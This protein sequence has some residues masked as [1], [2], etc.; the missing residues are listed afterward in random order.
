[1]LGSGRFGW[2]GA[3]LAEAKALSALPVLISGKG[4]GG[5]VGIWERCGQWSPRV[6]LMH[7]AVRLFCIYPRI[8]RRGLRRWRGIK[9][10]KHEDVI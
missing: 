10:Q 9:R 8:G 3:L 2:L 5:G 4:G 6:F 7:L 1:L